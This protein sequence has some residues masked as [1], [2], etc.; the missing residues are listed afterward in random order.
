[1]RARG[2]GAAAFHSAP[3]RSIR[4]GWLSVWRRKNQGAD[5]R[6]DMNGDHHA[7]LYHKRRMFFAQIAP[8]SIA[9][10]WPKLFRQGGLHLSEIHQYQSA[11]RTEK[12]GQRARRRIVGKNSTSLFGEPGYVA[13]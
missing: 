10:L 7:L 1:M 2:Y 12:A 4:T 5:R 6:A 9:P 3:F 13:S 8:G 11:R